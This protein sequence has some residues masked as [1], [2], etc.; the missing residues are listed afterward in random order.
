MGQQVLYR[1]ARGSLGLPELPK[2]VVHLPRNA[3]RQIWGQLGTCLV[4]NQDPVA[5]LSSF[6]PL[7]IYVAPPGQTGWGH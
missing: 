3:G 4:G 2:Y 1:G 5:F 7:L 6:L